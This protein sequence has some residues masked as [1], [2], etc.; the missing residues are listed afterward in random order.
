MWLP[1]NKGIQDWVD[2]K[3]HEFAA[4]E[5]SNT[6]ISSEHWLQNYIYIF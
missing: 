4:D 3:E 6:H 2:L 5:N 1:T